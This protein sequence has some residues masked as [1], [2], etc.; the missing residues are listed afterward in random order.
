M[1]GRYRRLDSRLLTCK[2]IALLMGEGRR[3]MYPN[4]TGYRGSMPRLM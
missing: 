3:T 2:G 4:P 1:K